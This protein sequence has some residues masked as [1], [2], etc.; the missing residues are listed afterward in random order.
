MS[1]SP[2]AARV[3]R[4]RAEMLDAATAVFREEGYDAASMDRIAAR[5]GASKR[6]V[7]NHFKNKEALF[8]AVV[9]RELEAAA[10]LKRVLWDPSRSLEA[11]LTDFARAKTGVMED[12]QWL[13]LLRV[14]LGVFIRDPELAQETMLRAM[15]DEAHLTR[16]LEA[17]HAAGA[18]EVPDPALTAELFW[19]MISGVLF[20]PQVLGGALSMEAQATRRDALITLFLDHHRGR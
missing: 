4:K 16:W 5:A 17:A 2:H 18:L 19:G 13:S 14:I 7:Y 11:Q 12:P 1:E 6:T 10:E 9:R 8:Q 3:S 15:S 20:W